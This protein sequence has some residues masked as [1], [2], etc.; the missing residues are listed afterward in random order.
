MPRVRRLVIPEGFTAGVLAADPRE[1][2]LERNP[3]ANADFS[4]AAEAHLS[5]AIARTLGRLS[6]LSAEGALSAE[7][8]LDDEALAERFGILGKRERLIDL[9]SSTAGSGTPVPRGLKQSVPGIITMMVLMMTLIY[10]GVFLTSEKQDGTLR[11]QAT[12][13]VSRLE[14]FAGKMFGRLLLCGLQLALLLIAGKLLFDMS[15][16]TSPLALLLLLATYSLAVAGMTIFLGAV[17]STPEQASSIGWLSTMVLAAM[18]GCWWP[19]EVMPDWLWSAA[20]VLPTAWAMDGFHSL[21][22]F[23]RGLEGVLAPSL[24]L[25][26]FSLLFTA[27]GARL[28]RYD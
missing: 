1:L 25:L 16:G 7:G 10:G 27:A 12:L 22:S 23:G 26:G 13:P 6:E 4:L 15:Y 28:L 5:R 24:A 20:H 19:S 14:L 2:T 17:C 9:D 18:G 8:G 3:D 21:I 11:R